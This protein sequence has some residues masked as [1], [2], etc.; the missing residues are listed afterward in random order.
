MK[1]L[2]LTLATPALNLGLDEALLQAC[3]E[4][5]GPETLRVWAPTEPF[6]VVGY[7]NRVAAE[8]DLEACAQRGIPILRRPSG[9]GTVLLGS[10][11]LCYAVVLRIEREPAL[12]TIEGTN[13]FVLDRVARALASCGVEPV[14]QLGH[15]DLVWRGR[16]CA[17]NAQRRCREA[18]LFHGS[19]LLGMDL[20]LIEAC[21]RMPTR[22]PGYREQRGHG[23]FLV[24]LP[25]P[26]DRLSRALCAAWQAEETHEHPPLAA[27]EALARQ[28]YLREDWNQR[29]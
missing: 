29:W 21:L 12:S 14:A 23:E 10:G 19:L 24:N 11:V 6:V 7:A 20:A 27:A 25:V 9:G 15:T 28:K 3:D 22:Q 13:R 2:D 18:V 8:V 1:Y 16:K 5:T 17:G 26:A 4:G